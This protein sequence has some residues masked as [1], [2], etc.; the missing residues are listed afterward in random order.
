MKIQMPWTYL[1][2]LQ[3]KERKYTTYHGDTKGPPQF[4]H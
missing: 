4:A 3:E 1:A 2:A